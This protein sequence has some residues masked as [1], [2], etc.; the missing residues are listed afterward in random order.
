[1]TLTSLSFRH[2]REN[3]EI[4]PGDKTTFYSPEIAEGYTTY[5]LHNNVANGQKPV[6]GETRYQSQTTSTYSIVV[7]TPG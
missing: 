5:I 1:M 7:C 4:A 6:L 2:L 3:V